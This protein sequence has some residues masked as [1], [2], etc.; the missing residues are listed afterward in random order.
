MIE[1]LRKDA[2]AR[3]KKTAE[4]LRH[5]L[6]KVRT[7][8]A[9]T[10]LLDHVL[11]PYY[12]SDVPLSQVANIAVA[13]ARM[14]TITPWEKA[15]VPAIEKAIMTSDLG[16]N[17]STSGM[18]IRVALPPLT[19]DRRRELVKV[20]RGDAEGAR[21]AVR[22]IRRDANNSVK[23][24]LKEKEITE[25]EQRRAEEQIQ[26]LTDHYIEEIDKLLAGKEA[27]LMAI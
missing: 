22:N 19:E 1:D 18:V 8:R 25:D 12:G 27:D 10:N 23:E 24:L 15:M 4:T 5:D 3:M 7:G 13:D 17:P 6:A 11:V 20:V 2:E 14:L 9:Q 26:K 16:L 21:I